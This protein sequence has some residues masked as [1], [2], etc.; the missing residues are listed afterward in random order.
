MRRRF[1]GLTL[2]PLL[3]AK[4]FVGLADPARLRALQAGERRITDLAAEVGGSQACR[5][6]GLP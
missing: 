4:L 1:T 2:P 3:A 6:R 5:G